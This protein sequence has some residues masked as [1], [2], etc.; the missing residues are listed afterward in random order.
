METPRL[1]AV[2]FGRAVT[3]F[4]EATGALGYR[5]AGVIARGMDEGCGGVEGHGNWWGVAASGVRVGIIGWLGSDAEGIRYQAD[6]IGVAGISDTGTG[7]YGST[8]SGSGLRGAADTGTGTAGDTQSGTG[9]AGHGQE[10]IAGSFDTETG[11][12]LKTTGRLSLLKTSGIATIPAGTRSK[13]ITPGVD[14]LSSSFILLTPRSDLGTR[15]LW[16]TTDATSNRFT[17]RLSSNIWS[18]VK[19][20]WL[21]IG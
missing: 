17:I 21:L 18:S 19:I 11:I 2:A 10:R 15:R 14:I 4:G 16:V 20:G 8:Q 5:Y 1:A 13:N 12:A 3:K 6:N 7:T 9:V